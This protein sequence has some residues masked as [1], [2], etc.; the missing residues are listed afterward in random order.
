MIP[1]TPAEF[2]KLKLECIKRVKQYVDRG[3]VKLG[4]T[5]NYPK[6][7]FDLRGTT[8]GKAFY[9]TNEVKFQPT[10]LFENPET[11]IEQ[12]AGHEVGHLLA[13][14]KFR[15]RGI[16]PHGSEWQ[17]VMWY[18][19]LPATRCHNYDTSNVSTKIGQPRQTIVRPNRTPFRVS[20][21][22]ARTD[23]GITIV[24]LD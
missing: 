6:V 23:G 15:D 8:A 7:S 4:T 17:S 9:Q 5:L 14:F 11:F 10:L 1:T 20:G 3:N 22:M 13:R 2:E 18:L 24:E 19:G 21:G 16:D 12:T